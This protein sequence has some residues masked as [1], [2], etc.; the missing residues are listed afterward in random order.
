MSFDGEYN[1]SDVEIRPWSTRYYGGQ[2]VGVDAGVI[3]V[4]KPTGLAV[5]ETEERSQMSNKHKAL[6]RLRAL[7]GVFEQLPQRVRV[8]GKC[9]C[10]AYMAG[11]CVC[12]AW[13][14]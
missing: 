6:D 5:V 12:G 7:V 8:D 14:R 2:H 9:D 11:E 10:H 4:H 3:V 13:D 1:E